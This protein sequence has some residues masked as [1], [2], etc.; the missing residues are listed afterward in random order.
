[1]W[2]AHMCGCAK[3]LNPYIKYSNKKEV[4]WIKIDG[5]I[6]RQDEEE[7]KFSYVLRIFFTFG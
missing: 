4:I 2:G 5:V 3:I 6:Y 1:M 7:K